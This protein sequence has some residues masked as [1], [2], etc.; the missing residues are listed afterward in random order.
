MICYDVE[1]FLWIHDVSN[2]ENL[3][4]YAINDPVWF[5]LYISADTR[6]SGFFLEIGTSE[7][8]IL[9]PQGVFPE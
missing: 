4:V 1:G 5:A 7:C 6:K 9:F 3:Q 2:C 8:R